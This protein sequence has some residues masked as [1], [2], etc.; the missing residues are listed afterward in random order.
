MLRHS[1]LEMFDLSL[2]A[3]FSVCKGDFSMSIAAQVVILFLVV[4]VGVLCRRLG[5][6]TDETI[7]GVTQL[8]VNV[9]LPVLTVY[10]M[11]RPF[12]VRVLMN[13]LLTLLISLA[14]ILAAIGGA[15]LLRRSSPTTFSI[16][17]K[18]DFHRKHTPLSFAKLLTLGGADT[19]PRCQREPFPLT[20]QSKTD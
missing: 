11:Q 7:R 8:V 1:F 6:F 20:R 13:F 19:N 9:T 3:P 4:L 12:D 16:N 18:R 2:A 15:S 17:R 10:N 5:Y 14:A